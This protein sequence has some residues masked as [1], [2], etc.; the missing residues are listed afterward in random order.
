MLC[1]KEPACGSRARGEHSRG[2]HPKDRDVGTDSPVNM[3]VGSESKPS[4]QRTTDGPDCIGCGI[5]E[6][7]GINYNMLQSL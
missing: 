6:R 1:D 5:R 4:G 7:F 2:R 3:K